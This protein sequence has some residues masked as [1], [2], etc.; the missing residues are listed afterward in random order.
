MKQVKLP[1]QT[2]FPP[3]FT[4]PDADA[5]GTKMFKSRLLQ[6]RMAGHVFS[7]ILH[8]G[9]DRMIVPWQTGDDLRK[10]TTDSSSLL[11]LK[12]PT[13]VENSH[14]TWMKCTQSNGSLTI[15]IWQP[16][17]ARMDRRSS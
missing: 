12:N 17:L 9:D 15:K 13:V 14:V 8:T 3:P 11:H 6:M 16:N 5:A 10:N 7:E 4:H 1:K 2:R